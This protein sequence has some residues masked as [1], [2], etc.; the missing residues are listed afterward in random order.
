MSTVEG[1]LPR[2]YGRPLSAT[3]RNWLWG[4]A[5]AAGLVALFTLVGWLEG[6]EQG[7]RKA[8]LVWNAS[9]TSTRF[10]AIGHTVVATAFL[11]TSK[12]MRGARGWAWFLSLTAAG[13][14]SCFAYRFLG[15]K[16]APLAEFLFYTYF[17]AH[18]I[19]DEL[20]F[21]RV[22]GDVPA[23]DDPKT[24]TRGLWLAPLLAYGVIAATFLSAAAF[25]I[26]GAR[27]YAAALE[28][29]AQPV[30]VAIGA[31]VIV[32]TALLLFAAQR[33]YARLHPGGWRGLLAHHR[34]LFVVFAMI[35]AIL[36]IGIAAT[37]RMY[38][39]VAVHV[40]I[41]YVF[42]L[43]QLAS[44]PA[45]SPRPRA[46]SWAWVRST[47][48]GFNFFHLGVMALVIGAAAY[49]AFVLQ[50]AAEPPALAVFVSK[51]SFPYWTLMHVTWSWVPRG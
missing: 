1:V 35:Y 18:E 20:F 3:E 14:A 38:A 39:I 24:A 48:A 10:L 31:V 34:P 43:K 45:P 22:N 32:A 51:E 30:R 37:G 42:T 41:W 17:L 33:R 36:M 29:L 40:A 26:G 46:F 6:Q 7:D 19:R 8:R 25:G 11:L 49:R 44:R 16:H 4:L 23:G 47:T 5:I 12:R 9:E 13:V 2:P 50:N 21:Y 28:D 27:R 15:G